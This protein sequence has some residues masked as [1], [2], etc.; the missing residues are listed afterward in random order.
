MISINQSAP[1]VVVIQNIKTLTV[2]EI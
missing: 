2:F 1:L